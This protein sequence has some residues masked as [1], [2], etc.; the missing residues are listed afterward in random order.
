[1]DRSW[2]EDRDDNMW[3]LSFLFLGVGEKTLNW[4]NASPPPPNFPCTAATAWSSFFQLGTPGFLSLVSI[5]TLH[6]R[7]KQSL[8][9]THVNGKWSSIWYCAHFPWSL[10]T[11]SI[12]HNVQPRPIP[13]ELFL[14][15]QLTKHQTNF[16]VPIILLGGE[17]PSRLC[18]V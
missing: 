4:G 16:M 2:T 3:E 12:M 11:E 1:M 17:K 18:A 15:V 5:K 6:R 8:L 14:V 13:R 9:C 10:D 7:Y